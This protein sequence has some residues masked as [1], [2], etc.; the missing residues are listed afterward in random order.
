MSVQKKHNINKDTWEKLKKTFCFLLWAIPFITFSFS[1]IICAVLDNFTC[2]II[3]GFPA[4]TTYFYLIF[5]HKYFFSYAKHSKIIS[6]AILFLIPYFF[7][8]SGLACIYR[9]F[10]KSGLLI[11]L[12]VLIPV[13]VVVCIR[14]FKYWEKVWESHRFHNEETVLDLKNGRYDFV[15]NFDMDE[16]ILKKKKQ[17]Q[18]SNPAIMS[19]IYMIAP[20]GVGLG[21]ILHRSEQFTFTFALL[22]A[23][24]I[25]ASLGFLKPFAASLLMYR[26]LSFYEKQIGKPIINGLLE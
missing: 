11:L 3:P 9:I 19:I 23:L 25:P 5:F 8:I 14:Y 12:S 26:K 21:M 24:S 15:R 10:G 7:S 18:Y 20:L 6:S 16:S 13:S 4:I 17:R 22:A 1:L 2:F